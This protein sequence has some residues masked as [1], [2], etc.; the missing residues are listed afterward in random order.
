MSDTRRSPPRPPALRVSFVPGVTPD[1]WA[2]TWAERLPRI[3]LEL[4]PVAEVE[5]TDVLYDG[6]ADMCFV[7][8]PVAPEVREDLHVIPLYEEVPVAVV[9][10]GHFVEAA[11][12]ITLADLDGE[13]ALEA[14]PLT[15]RQA[16]ETIAA[17]VGVIVLPMS[18]ARLH[19]RRD[20][21]HRPVTDAPGSAVGLA[22]RRDLEDDRVEVFIGVVRGRTAN[23]SRGDSPRRRRRR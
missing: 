8:L 12:E 7:R 4:S 18:V 16:V 10:K 2:R 9:P 5:Q 17:G 23:S 14:P 13:H 22:W 15:V 3:P 20:V 19:H 1:K 11:D 6:R 21:V